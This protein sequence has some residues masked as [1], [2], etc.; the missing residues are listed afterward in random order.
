VTDAPPSS[1][2]LPEAAPSERAKPLPKAWPVVPVEL[3]GEAANDDG[4]AS[5]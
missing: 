2:P 1:A 5:G 4:D 3:R